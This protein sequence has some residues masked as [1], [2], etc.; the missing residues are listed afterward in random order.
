MKTLAVLCAAALFLTAG[1]TLGPDFVRPE[2][3][4]AERYTYGPQ[5]SATAR[6]AGRSQE[7][8]QGAR[9]AARW[10]GLFKSPKVDA[11]VREA[12]VNSPGLLAAQAGLRQSQELLRAGEGVFYPQADAGFDATRQKF[13][14]ARFGG[15]AASSIFN[16][17]TLSATVSYALDVFGGERRRVEGLGAQVDYQRYIMLGTYLSL[18]GNIINTMIAQ[19]AYREEIRATGH[20]IDLEKEQI[21]ITEAQAEA[22]T[23]PYSNVLSLQS[24]LAA[25]EAALPPLKQKLSQANHLLAVLTGRE[26]AQWRPPEIALA[27]LTLPAELPVSLPSDLARQRP[28][29]LASEAQVHAASANIGVAT[30]AMFPSF[31]LNGSYGLESTSIGNLFKSTSSIWSLGAGVTAP[32]FHGGT[33]SAE[34]RAAIEACNQS[35]QNYRQTVLGALAQVADTLRGLEHDAQALNAQSKAVSAAEEALRLIQANYQAGTVNYLQVL[36]A[37]GLYYQAKISYIQ[38][39]AQW[40]QDTVALFAALGGGW[41]NEGEKAR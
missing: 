9:V 6:A 36:T 18:S 24:Q 21:S 16:L 14:Q 32:L 28:D 10:W 25:I 3:P 27:D 41:W 26:P 38:A 17:Y 13:S 37:D 8:R 4:K 12:I 11:V 33:L 22:G 2:P 39:Q 35:L 34:R 15:K 5:P 29:I 1:C 19:A 31:A 23:V 20:L 40:L 7:F 30:A